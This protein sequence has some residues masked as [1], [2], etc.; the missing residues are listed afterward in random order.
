MPVHVPQ[1][2]SQERHA[3]Q[4]RQQRISRQGFR[5]SSGANAQDVITVDYFL[6]SCDHPTRQ[7]NRLALQEKIRRSV[8]AHQEVWPWEGGG[9][10]CEEQYSIFCTFDFRLRSC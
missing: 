5:L 2:A 9:V 8:A 3:A 6:N 1:V 7:Q 4:Q 10:Q